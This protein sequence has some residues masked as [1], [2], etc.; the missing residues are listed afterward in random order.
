[1]KPLI[2]SRLPAQAPLGRVTVPAAGSTFARRL[3]HPG[4]AV[5]VC[6][7]PFDPE[8]HLVRPAVFVVVIAVAVLAVVG[9][10]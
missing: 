10:L 6:T 7:R 8:R 1:M 5:E 2:H 9:A 3:A 4:P